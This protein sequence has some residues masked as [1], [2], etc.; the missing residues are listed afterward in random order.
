MSKVL[1]NQ[2]ILNGEQMKKIKNMVKSLKKQSANILNYIKFDVEDNHITATLHYY[3]D[4]SQFTIQQ[5][6]ESDRVEQFSFLLPLDFIKKLR[7]IKNNDVFQFEKIKNDTVKLNKNNAIQIIKTA[8]VTAFPKNKVNKLK[9]I[10]DIDYKEILNLVKATITV[11]KTD[12]RP[13]L[14]YVLIRNGNIYSTDSY[15]LYTTQS[16]INYQDDV[17]LDVLAIKKLKDVF[18][19]KDKIGVYMD[20]NSITFQTLNTSITMNKIDTGSYP[21]IEKLI[22][23]EYVINYKLNNQMLLQAVK[24]SLEIAKYNKPNNMIELTFI[25][26]QLTITVQNEDVGK[27]ENTIDIINSNNQDLTVYVNAKYLIDGLKQIEDDQICLKFNNSL[28][29]FVIT[30]KK[31]DEIALILPIRKY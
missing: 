13:I 21:K 31:G 1:T 29:P 4:N 2:V 16:Q 3:N 23:S 24:E 7:H 30:N 10:S 15:R 11:S 20:E 17:L 9:H 25:D 26:N 8:D 5:T 28:K 18:S 19:K 12:S 6:F 14:K 22:D 27:Y